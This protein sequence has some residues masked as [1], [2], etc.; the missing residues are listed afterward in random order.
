MRHYKLDPST[1]L[2]MTVKHKAFTLIELIT[3][4]S[5]IGIMSAVTIVS[6]SS[7]R[8][9]ARLVSAQREVASAIKLAQSY[10][11]QGKTVNGSTP[12]GFGAYFDFTGNRNIYKIYPI[13]AT[14]CGN[15]DCSNLRQCSGST[16]GFS[17]PGVEASVLKDGVKFNDTVHSGGYAFVYFNVP[18]GMAIIGGRANGAADPTRSDSLEIKFNYPGTTAEKSIT[19]NSAGLVTEN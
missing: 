5:I 3:V 8:A 6:L 10:A 13:I 7:S 15:I 12:C 4:I 2:G 18:H 17:D 16:A 11:L 9:N 1:T 14:N 19:V